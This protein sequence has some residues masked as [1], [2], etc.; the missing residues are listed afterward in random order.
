MN[1]LVN[2]YEEC[3]KKY[4]D[5]HRGVDWP[6]K[7]GADK[8]YKVMLQIREYDE[9]QVGHVPCFLDYGCGLGHMYEYIEEKRLLLGYMGYDL[10]KLLVYR[11]REKHPSKWWYTE[12]PPEADY[13][14][15]NGVF[16][17][18]VGMSEEEAVKVM[19]EELKKAWKLCRNGI[20]FNVMSTDTDKNRTDLLRM[21]IGFVATLVRQLTDKYIIRCDYKTFE[22]TVYAYKH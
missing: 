13:V 12:N 19:Q 22:Y 15:M 9:R 21:P 4:G 1:S 7:E 11:C 18:R 8:R 17:E 16:T 5:N 14:V 10:S 20:A 6:D 3:Y 2:H